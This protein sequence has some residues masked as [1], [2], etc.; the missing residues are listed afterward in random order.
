MEKGIIVIVAIV[1]VILVDVLEYKIVVFAA[2]RI[3]S[4][5]ATRTD[6]SLTVTL[7][8]TALAG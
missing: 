5:E 6:R 1:G 7:D 2:F 3:A 4:H 8:L